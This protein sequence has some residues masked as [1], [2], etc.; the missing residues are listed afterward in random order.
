MQPQGAG[1]QTRVSLALHE[2][3]QAQDP[4][5]THNPG[6]QIHKLLQI[7]SYSDEVVGKGS[8]KILSG[9]GQ[10]GFSVRLSLCMSSQSRA[11]Y[12]GTGQL[13][14]LKPLSAARHCGL[15]A[16]L[17]GSLEYPPDTPEFM[18]PLSQERADIG[19]DLGKEISR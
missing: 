1:I 12:R 8:K 3:F 16:I 14:A 11:K 6:H 19:G 13:V 9:T 2:G 15:G 17:Q 4:A 7:T 5:R 18:Y 10:L